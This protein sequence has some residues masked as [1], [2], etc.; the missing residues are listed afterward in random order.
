[1]NVDV[2]VSIERK[3]V[4]NERVRNVLARAERDWNMNVTEPEL[5]GDYQRIT[6]YIKSNETYATLLL[7][8]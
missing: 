7:W 5:G 3:V 4:P 6:Y 8:N 2:N 1:M